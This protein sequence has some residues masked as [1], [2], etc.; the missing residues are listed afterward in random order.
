MTGQ[1]CV[2]GKPARFCSQVFPLTKQHLKISQLGYSHAGKQYLAG[3]SNTSLQAGTSPGPLL[4]HM[5]KNE[6][7]KYFNLLKFTF[8]HLLREL[9][10]WLYI[11]DRIK[12]AK[13]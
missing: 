1:V 13:I 5:K 8:P 4:T 6:C 2:W 11:L 3:L 10:I 12:K 9:G 7:F